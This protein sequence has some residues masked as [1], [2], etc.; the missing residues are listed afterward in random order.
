MTIIPYALFEISGYRYGKMKA[1][2]LNKLLQENGLTVQDRD[3][4]LSYL[5]GN[6]S[7]DIDHS[8]FTIDIDYI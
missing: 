7:I 3:M 2:D 4:E 6:Y 5:S 1:E 8:L